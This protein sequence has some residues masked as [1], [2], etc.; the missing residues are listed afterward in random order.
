MESLENLGVIYSHKSILHQ[1]G[2]FGIFGMMWNGY[3]RLYNEKQSCSFSLPNYEHSSD[4]LRVVLLYIVDVNQLYRMPNI[5][6]KRSHVS[7]ATR[8]SIEP[9]R[10]LWWVRALKLKGGF[11]LTLSICNK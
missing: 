10:A 4:F 11:M 7:I 3:Q 9:T 5:C 1:D 8:L 6:V 2:C